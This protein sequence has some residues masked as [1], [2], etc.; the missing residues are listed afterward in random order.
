MIESNLKFTDKSAVITQ[1][2]FFGTSPCKIVIPIDK[3]DLVAQ[4]LSN[5]YFKWQSQTINIIEQEYLSFEIL[6]SDRQKLKIKENLT[7]TR[8][9]DKDQYSFYDIYEKNMP[10]TICQDVVVFNLRGA[11][12]LSGLLKT[13]QPFD[14]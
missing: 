8:N 6:I 3:I 12:I 4:I 11:Y 7:N 14:W 2:G 13:R 10:Y 5:M 1:N 9:Q